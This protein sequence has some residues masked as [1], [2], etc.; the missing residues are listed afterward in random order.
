M[1]VWCV[2]GVCVCL[3][4][5]WHNG[6]S[7]K[8]RI[9]LQKRLRVYIQYVPLYAGT[10]RTC[11]EICVRGVGTHGDVLNV[12]T[13]T[14]SIHTLGGRSHRQFCLPKFAH[15]RLSRASEVHQRNFWIFRIFKCE[16][17]LRTTCP[18]ILHSFAFPDKAVQF[19]LSEGNKLP[20]CPVGLSPFSPSITNDVNVS[21]ATSLHQR[22]R[23]SGRVHHLSS[24]DTLCLTQT[25]FK[26]T[27]NIHILV[28]IKIHMRIHIQIHMRIHIQIH[29]RI[30]S[31]IPISICTCRQRHHNIRNGI[32]WAQ[33]GHSTC[34]CTATLCVIEL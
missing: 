20:D 25:T 22:L 30:R 9:W 34:T 11:V 1:C 13:G 27:E 10:T 4:V 17:R 31:H 6:K 14:F 12:H 2:F 28:H 26:I 7:G 16:K 5:L 33:T 29:I 8:N 3:C 19:R 23:F 24:P 18:R 15:V 32:V 21:V